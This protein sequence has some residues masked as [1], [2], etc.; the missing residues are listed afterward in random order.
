MAF[1]MLD[2]GRCLRECR[3]ADASSS[4]S[5]GI[6]MSGMNVYSFSLT[7]SI[8]ERDVKEWRA[9]CGGRI[10]AVMTPEFLRAVEKSMGTEARF[11]N[12]VFRDAAGTPAAAAFLSLQILDGLL[13]AS[14][15]WKRYGEFLR[16]LWPGFLKVKVL[17]CGCPVSTG[18]SQ[19]RIAPHADAAVLLRQMDRL[20]TRLAG[21]EGTLFVIFKEFGPAEI[22]RTDALCSLGYL[23][24]DSL[25]MN[26]FPTRFRDFEHFCASIRSPYR[27][28]ILHSRH[29][30]RR[31]GL[32]VLH[33]RGGAGLD[34]LYTD[35]VHGLYQAVLDH[36]AIQFECL[37][38]AFF[39]EL[40]R[41]LPEDSLFTLICRGEQ[42]VA[43]VCG[44]FDSESYHNLFCGFDYELNNQADLYFNLLY[45]N[46]DYALRQNVRTLYVGQTADDFKSRAGCFRE[47]RYF[48][49]KTRGPG[50]QHLLRAAGPYLFPPSAPLGERNLFRNSAG[51]P[52]GQ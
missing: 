1:A 32:R 7:R 6:T 39:R 3:A 23:R 27:R 4:A 2:S 51:D 28:K 38:A 12:V 48:Y 26:Y 22:G 16:R 41:Q 8:D 24:A 31:A 19:L 46:L 49:V 25:P 35:D 5:G 37:P 50:L 42:V 15:R 10:D 20:M 17:L 11:C 34:A 14:P 36:A 43:F 30:L 47:P 33:L 40:A 18:E 9:A 52:P 44:I 45:E 29:K 13:L 21:Q